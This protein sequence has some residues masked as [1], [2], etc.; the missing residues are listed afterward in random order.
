M[1]KK[2]TFESACRRVPGDPLHDL[3][4]P[5]FN[6]SD[7]ECMRIE[8]E[9]ECGHARRFSW[10]RILD[11]SGMPDQSRC[12]NSEGEGMEWMSRTWPE[13]QLL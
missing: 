4:L 12:G 2:S 10:A 1:V 7:A 13:S 5:R 3:S 6:G 9:V 8:C 11:K